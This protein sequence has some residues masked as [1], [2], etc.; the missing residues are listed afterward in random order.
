[1]LEKNI[2]EKK[3]ESVQGARFVKVNGLL[4]LQKEVIREV[5]C[6]QRYLSPR[7]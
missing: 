1:M 4:Q 2:L 7:D 6:G 5:M 3:E